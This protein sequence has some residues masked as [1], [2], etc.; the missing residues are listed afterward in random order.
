M[1]YGNFI[2]FVLYHLNFILLI[3]FE[4]G[5]LKKNGLYG[6]LKKYIPENMSFVVFV[7]PTGKLDE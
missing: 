7:H 5:T 2:L 1:K 4:V 6:K 3:H